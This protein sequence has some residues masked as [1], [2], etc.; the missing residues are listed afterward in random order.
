MYPAC[1]DF[2]SYSAHARVKAL[3]QARPP[4]LTTVTVLTNPEL[5]NQR[6]SDM[7][8]CGPKFALSAKLFS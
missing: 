5:M 3:E 7:I 4:P 6:R 2:Y 1:Q 8:T